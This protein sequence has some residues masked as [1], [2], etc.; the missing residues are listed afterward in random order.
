MMIFRDRAMIATVR[1]ISTRTTPSVAKARMVSSSS[2]PMSTSRTLPKISRSLSMPGKSTG[3]AAMSVAIVYP[4]SAVASST[5]T[6]VMAMSTRVIHRSSFFDEIEHGA[7]PH[8]AR[9]VHGAQPGAVKPWAG[10]QRRAA[11]TEAALVQ[12]AGARRVRRSAPPVVIGPPGEGI[13]V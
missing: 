1:T 11:A 3:G 7:S 9:G 8:R 4:S 5:T 12:L 2:M 6:A 10:G 13:G